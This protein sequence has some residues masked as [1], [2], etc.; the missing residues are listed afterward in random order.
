MEKDKNTIY[1]IQC[2]KCGT[3]LLDKDLCGQTEC[4]EC[5][6]ELLDSGGVQ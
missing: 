5:G 2:P 3:E 4:P 6:T 1:D